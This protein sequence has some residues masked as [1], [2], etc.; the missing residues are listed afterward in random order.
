VAINDT[1]PTADRWN[2]ATIEILAGGT[3][4]QTPSVPTGL[5][6]DSVSGNR[7]DLSWTASSDDFG[8]AG[9]RVF[10]DGAQIGTP[11]GTSFSDTTVTPGH[12]YA[13]TVAA[14]DAAGHVSD[15][16]APL[17]VTTPAPDTTAPTVSLT[18]PATGSTVSATITVRADA[19]DNVGVTGVQFLLD[20]QT[21]GAEDASD[22][23][24]ASWDTTT[25]GNGSHTL[26]ARARDA[27]GNQTTSAPV[28]VTVSNTDPNDPAVVGQWGP[29]IPLPAVAI[30]NA[31]TPTGKILMF[32]GSFTQGGQQYE[33]D[34]LTGAATQI[35]D[36]SPNLF[37]AAQAVLA[38]GR[39]QVAGGTNIGSGPLGLKDAV[40]YDWTSKSWQTLASMK[41]PRWY[42]TTTTLADG[43]VLAMSGSNQTSTDLVPI[44]ELYNPVTNTWKTLD[45][46]SRTVPFYPFMYQL[47]N[48]K[49][50]RVGATEEATPTETLDLN[51]NQWQTVDSR[52]LDGGSSANYAPGKFL[53]AGTSSD[54]GFSGQSAATAYTL[55]MNQPS[56]Q[57]QATQSMNFRRSFLNL[58]N[59]PDGTV[60]ATGGGTDRS[61]QIDANAVL[62]AEDWNPDTG[63]WTKYAAMSKPRLY[64]S[65]AV[66]LPDGRVYVSGGGGDTGVTNQ[67]T[68]QIFS[69]P[70]LF[71]GPRPTITSVPATVQWDSHVTVGTPDGSSIRRVS[72]IR[73]GSVTHAFD[74][75]ARAMSLDFTQTVG[76]I[77]VK[78]PQNGNY[79]PPGYYLLFIVSDQGVPSVA[80]YVRFPA[81]YEDATPPTAPTGLSATTQL[82]QAS[83]SWTAASDNQGV[84][85]YNVHRSTTPGFTPSAANKVGTSTTT[86]FTDSGLAA[87]DY[88]YRVTA[89]D[90]VGNVGP[91]SDEAPATVPRD[92]TPPS[93]PTGLSGTATARTASLTWSASTDD[94]AVTGYRVY[95]DGAQVGTSATPAFSDSGLTPST[96]YAYRVAAYDAE[97]NLSGQSQ[98]ANITTTSDVEPIAVDKI[99]TTH[100]ASAATAIASPAL[101]TSRAG[102]LLVAFVALDGPASGQTVN[103]IAGGG[104]TWKLRQRT[105]VQA[106]SAEIWQAAAPAALS[107][108]VITATLKSRAQGSLAVVALTGADTATLGAVGSANG[109]TG[110][111]RVTLTTTRASSWVWGVGNDWDGSV[112]RTLGS[113]QTL[114][115]QYFSPSGDT[116]WVQRRDATTPAAGTSVTIDDTA[117]TN[118]RWNL[119]A[120]E[121]LKAP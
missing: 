91:A 76:G 48:G 31:L 77:D 27:A 75:N 17:T 26:A 55:D 37:C 50:I 66:L 56:P 69:P 70:Y 25:A 95:R 43:K 11:A 54:G 85:N 10:R 88:Y 1:A 41:Y 12:Q 24:T 9:Y 59:L 96:T 39:V 80:S 53:K 47:P 98:P 74:E 19:G 107:N 2:L 16:S 60:L 68:G 61:A 58:T 89:E 84:T 82:G 103:S 13:Y 8:V 108:A 21:L 15:Q 5:T 23:Y 101:T 44:P 105:N 104:L 93:V 94:A 97:G 111:Q 73:T 117:P 116:Y 86:S 38:D 102:E 34:P 65:G 40:A 67:L 72:L 45:A 121:I 49:M 83:L 99:V 63:T 4:T 42:A 100:Q 3:D 30:H 28:Q 64:H 33:V 35:V 87:G 71:K 81:P 90:A 7:V 112:A 118:H 57:W 51:T 6:A 14:Y 120:L 119:S 62:Q 110:A 92:S 78:M 46:A 36:A 18:A 115:D 109:S 79:A 29:L 32:E 113:G 52:L 22:P 20:G 114:V 106:G